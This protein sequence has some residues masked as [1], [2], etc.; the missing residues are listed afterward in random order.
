[1]YKNSLK[2]HNNIALVFLMD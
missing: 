2:Q 1:M